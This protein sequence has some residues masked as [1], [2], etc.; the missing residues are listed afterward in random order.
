MDGEVGLSSEI[1]QG[2]TFWFTVRLEKSAAIE[3][4][5]LGL[6]AVPAGFGGHLLVCEDDPVNQLVAELHLTALGLTVEVVS[7]GVAAVEAAARKHYDLVMLDMRLPDMDG[8]DVCRAIRKQQ[9]NRKR[10]P[11]VI[12]TASMAGVD[13]RLIADVGADSVLSKPF[14]LSALKQTLSRFLVAS[15]TCPTPTTATQDSHA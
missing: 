1:G 11:I 2:S 15:A 7:S 10:V 8:L 13:H 3:R 9:G 6:V 4:V 14:E 5:S 12:W